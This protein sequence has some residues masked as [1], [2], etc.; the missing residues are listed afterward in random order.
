VCEGFAFF[1]RLRVLSGLCKSAGAYAGFT[2]GDEVGAGVSARA[3]A[4]GLACANLIGHAAL[5]LSL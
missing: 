2:L 1:L 3:M 5:A 4:V